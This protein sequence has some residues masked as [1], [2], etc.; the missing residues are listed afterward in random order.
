LEFDDSPSGSTQYRVNDG[1]GYGWDAVLADESAWFLNN[2]AGSEGFNGSL[3]GVGVATYPQEIV[4]V[5]RRDGAMQRYRVNDQPGGIVAN[6]P[7][8]DESRCIVVGYDSG[9]GVVT[10]WRYD[11]NPTRLW[12]KHWNHAGHPLLFPESG[13]V[14]LGD[15][16]Q[17]RG[18]DVVLFVDIETG[19]EL[20]RVDTESP[21]QSVLFGAAG[22]A[23]DIYMCT[24]TTVTRISFSV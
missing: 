14:V 5:S 18:I 19:E 21:L 23:N 24:F 11:E 9:N 2:G 15:F 22:F 17:Q 1:E 4:R 12:T 20:A 10:A 8:V 16:D 7:A 3:R 6:P 13:I